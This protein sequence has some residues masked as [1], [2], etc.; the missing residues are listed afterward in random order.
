MNT[1]HVTALNVIPSAALLRFCEPRRNGNALDLLEMHDGI[2][3]K[4]HRV[5]DAKIIAGI[6]QAF[7]S[8]QP[9]TVQPQSVKV[10]RHTFH[11]LYCRECRRGF[12]SATAKKAHDA[13]KHSELDGESAGEV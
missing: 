2:V 10:V 13:Y 9:E 8:V 1:V 6:A 12:Q 4:V 3:R 11:P 5:T 7:L